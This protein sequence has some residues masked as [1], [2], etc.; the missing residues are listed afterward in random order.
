MKAV[1]FFASTVKALS[2]H[3]VTS[4]AKVIRIL[5][6]CTGVQALAIWCP[7]TLVLPPP[8]LNQ[9]PL[10]RVSMIRLILVTTTVLHATLKPLWLST[11]THLDLSFV[12]SQDDIPLA[13]MLRQL[14]HLTNIAQD[15]LTAQSSV[16][17]AACASYPNL[18]VFVIFGNDL[19]KS[20]RYSFDLRVVVVAPTF[21]HSQEWDAALLG[22]PDFWTRAESV[23][24]ERKARAVVQ[25][26]YSFQT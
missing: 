2:L 10:R 22:L 3:L 14:P 21:A 8:L 18:R 25:S 7:F 26:H 23:V 5:A 9:L 1:G 17:A 4:D 15:I 6:A 19:E 24:D 11:L 20:P 13:D 12:P 16:V